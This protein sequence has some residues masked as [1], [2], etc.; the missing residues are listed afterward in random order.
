LGS[1]LL[2][3]LVLGLGLGLGCGGTMNTGTAKK[4][5]TN[6][7]ATDGTCPSGRSAC[8]TGGFAICADLEN[9]PN[10]CGACDH[11]CSPGIACQAGVCQ[12]TPCTG[13][14]AVSGQPA[15]T[16]S[17]AGE[18]GPSFGLEILADVN[19]DGRPDLV[20]WQLYSGDPSLNSFRVSLAQPGGGFAAPDRYPTTFDVRNIVA[21]DAN[22][23]GVDD[24]MVFS[25]ADYTKPPTHLD[26]WLGHSDG[27]LT[28]L[29]SMDL[30]GMAAPLAVADLS[31][32]GLPDLVTVST[33][34][35]DVLSVYLSDST[36]ALH[37]S[38]TYPSSGF[39]IGS[40]SLGD[41][42]GDGSPD[43]VALG[44]TLNIW[45]NRGNGIFD[46]AMDCVILFP[47]QG[48]GVVT[49]FNHDG[50]MDLAVPVAGQT[51]GAGASIGIILGLGGCS[52]TPITYYDVPGNNNQMLLAA[53]MNG[54]GQ[55]DLVSITCAYSGP[56][57][58]TVVEDR[59]LTVLLGD[60]D[61]TFR[62]QG[63][64]ASQ[65]VCTSW[66]QAAIVEAT[67][68]H[69]PDIVVSTTGQVTILENT[70]Q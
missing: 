9:D 36:G 3:G 58:N 57:L 33:Y 21:T 44:N 41:Q 11:A 46:E 24:L 5:A 50:L 70:C 45:Y 25:S 56:L 68:D 27:K 19:G 30:D 7:P 32:D 4:P 12:Q 43:I 51:T 26:V 54:D 22:N 59:L 35:Q 39:G 13:P 49:D 55:L 18:S 2:I 16:S 61:G 23:D 10:R 42:N 14:V 63:T 17:D 64:V 15:P 29:S 52:F 47:G 20:Q 66:Y 34:S 28:K 62:P 60:P 6:K 53:D 67:G 37:F 8:G 31:G 69:S 40:F 48:A 1:A 38:K 65:G